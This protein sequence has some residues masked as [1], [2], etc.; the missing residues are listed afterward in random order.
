ME[1]RVAYVVH[2]ARMLKLAGLPDPEGSAK[3]IMALETRLAKS[4]WDRVK[5]RDD[6]LTYNKKDR[7]AL[8]ELPR[9]F[10][11]P[12]SFD[13]LGAKGIENEVGERGRWPCT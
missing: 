8:V 5:S 2:V 4:H 12:A 6:T 3:S 13:G 9:G 1:K 7:K 10:D 11:W